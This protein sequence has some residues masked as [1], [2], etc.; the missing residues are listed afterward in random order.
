M[1]AVETISRPEQSQNAGF[2]TSASGQAGGGSEEG[3]ALPISMPRLE[4]GDRMVLRRDEEVALIRRGRQGDRKAVERLVQMNLRL[5]YQ[6]ARRYRCRSYLTEDLVQEGAVGLMRAIERF[7]ERHGCRLSTYAMHWI[8]QSIAR[9]VEQNDRLIHVPMHASAEQRRL[10]KLR[11]EHQRDRGYPPS[12]AELAE[13]T[14]I[15]EERVAQ[16]LG[17]VQDTLSLEALTGTE[18]DSSLLEMTVDRTAPDPEEDALLKADRQRLRSLVATLRE[19]ERQVLEA[20]FGFN[21]GEPRTLEDLS[22]QLGVSRERVRQIETGAIRK[23]RLALRN[24][25]WD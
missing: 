19:R 6:V 13:V 11:E 20:R 7:D 18:G 23:L 24:S 12:D 4:A 22:R 2:G 17:T 9:A 10:L 8:R 5:V 3:F 14:G 25:G 21:G 15:R 16:L 1:S